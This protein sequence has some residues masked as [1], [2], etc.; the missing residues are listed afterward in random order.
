[1][2][3]LILTCST[4]EGHN[5]CAAALTQAFEEAGHTCD[6]MDAL[7]L[8]SDR[9]SSFVCNWHTR[10]YRYIPKAFSA[11][12][13]CAENHRDAAQERNK[14]LSY[15]TP[16]ARRLHGLLWEKGYDALICAHV[17]GAS[18]ATRMR[19]LY[20]PGVLTCFLATD[21]TCSPSVEDADA[22]LYFIPASAL[23]E[24]FIQVGIPSHKLIPTGIPVRKPFLTATK[25]ASAKKALSLPPGQ[26]HVLLMGGSMGCGPMETLAEDLALRLP[27]NAFLSVVC[28]TNQRLLH[29]LE[30][31]QLPRTRLYGFTREIPLLMD[32]ASLLLTKPG[33]ISVT[34]AGCK[35][36]PMLL[37]Q[38]VG[39]CEAYNLRYFTQRGWA[40]TAGDPY[41]LTDTCISM[42][43]DPDGLSRCAKAL[44]TAFQRDPAQI[45]TA[46]L[47]ERLQESLRRKL[48]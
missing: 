45:I 15:L 44:R 40:R 47:E 23:A 29:A 33:G 24:A 3:V 19:M 16:A 37:V 8:L 6:T 34:E 30:K 5:S 1:M 35:G 12:Y 41:A 14:R 48:G 17:F 22:D 4:G 10:I 20:G 27:E 46:C 28:G 18:I 32:S 2:R 43:A 36:L 13:A 26:P 11:G 42:L 21:Y 39:G 7:C 31:K 25:P 38:A 9:L